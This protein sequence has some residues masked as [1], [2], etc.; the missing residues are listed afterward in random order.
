MLSTSISSV[1]RE[2]IPL[3]LAAAVAAGGAAWALPAGWPSGAAV[4]VALLLLA[5]AAVHAHR[6]TR[7]ISKA[8]SEWQLTIDTVPFPVLA[9]DGE[10]RVM[11][12]NRAA[13]LLT[14]R[15]YVDNLGLPL[16]DLG[17]G[18]PW[19]CAAALVERSWD[20][21]RPHE[22]RVHDGDA[23]RHWE[24]A[25][26]PVS[27][28]GDVR[29]GCVVVAR[30]VT[31]RMRLEERLRRREVMSALG[32]LVASVAHEV[33]NPLFGIDA[34][35]Q[36]LDKRLAD[37]RELIPHLD[38]LRQGTRHLRELMQALLDYGRPPSPSPEEIP[39]A[40]LF[41]D[42]HRACAALADERGVELATH[43]PPGLPVPTADRRRLHQALS[44][45]VENAI[46]HSPPGAE[47]TLAAR[48]AYGCL[49]I[50]VRDRGDGFRTDHLPRLFEPFFTRRSGGT[51]LGLAIVQRVVDEHGGELTAD[52]HPGGGARVRLWLPAEPA[53]FHALAS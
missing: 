14:G 43:A 25:T 44:N 27:A 19:A 31:D 39:L 23:E 10:G 48:D 2:P 40:E 47:V 30:D 6:L 15:S 28:A 13:M 26:Q 42:V 33:R 49:E 5:T 1:L 38:T 37:R 53:P 34:S 41:A 22:D 18:E 36:V 11:R 35:L 7:R 4:G 20:D 52:N 21:G 24:V 32:S 3:L 29:P 50:E 8:A 51:G 12:L 9:L 46:H 17:L 16:V 45:L